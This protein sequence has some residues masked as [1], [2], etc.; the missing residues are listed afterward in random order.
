MIMQD[1]E[2][3]TG[4]RGEAKREV[5]LDA[6][7]RCFLTDGFAVSLDRIAAEADVSKQTIYSHFGNKEGLYRAV[8]LRRK[9]P[10]HEALRADIP[11]REALFR[12]GLALLEKVT[13]PETVRL[14]R[15]LV[16]QVS[17]FPDLARI[18]HEIGP[19]RSLE[20]LADYLRP[21]VAAGR[22][23]VEDAELAADHF[24]GLLL[25]TTRQRLL[26]GAMPSP[27]TD[28]NRRVA[29]RAVAAFCRA[30]CRAEA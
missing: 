2:P 18:H 21:L 9:W 29:E 13:A 17:Q 30:Y 6:A 1:D 25:G 5:I 23:D 24:F 20:G 3:R 8:A 14:H 11:V 4:R 10:V 12:F 16:G 15:L 27:S 22:L 28:D 26:F 7:E 19:Q